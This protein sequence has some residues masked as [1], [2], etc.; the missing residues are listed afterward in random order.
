[1]S[2]VS[3]DFEHEI[4]NGS[5]LYFGKSANVKRDIESVASAILKQYKFDEIVTPFFFVSSKF[6]RKE[7]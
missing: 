3:A 7:F 6:G 2:I 4:P 5:K 1:M